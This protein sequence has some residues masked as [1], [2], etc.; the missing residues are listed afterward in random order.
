[1]KHKIVLVHGMGAHGKG[2][3]A[4]TQKKF[5]EQ[6]NKLKSAFAPNF[7]K[8]FDF[9]EVTYDHVFENQ[10]ARW[11]DQADK[12][13]ESLKIGGITSGAMEELVEATQSLGKDNFFTTHVLDVVLYKWFPLM[14]EEVRL[15]VANTFLETAKSSSQW[16]IIAHSLGTAVVHDTLE[17]MFTEN[18]DGKLL[19]RQYR[20]ANLWMVANVSR[21]V[22]QNDVYRS[23]VK[24]TLNSSHG[25]CN[26]Y[27]SV[28]HEFDPFPMVKPFQSN[29]PD[30]IRWR[31]EA[32]GLYLHV[33][34]AGKNTHDWNVHALSHYLEVPGCFFSIMQSFA[35]NLGINSEEME[36]FTKTYEEKTPDGMVRTI[37]EKFNQIN[38][39]DLSTIE[40]F[41]KTLRI[42]FEFLKSQGVSH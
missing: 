11:K 20:P 8:A 23:L 36:K 6:Y 13:Y 24:P 21:V 2:W 17:A 35:G 40:D 41:I 14:A 28:R 22:S 10:R 26:E 25:L 4:D 15:N 39:N 5:K 30:G 16:S 34:L 31:K 3:S 12:I 42:F 38:S 27:F 18:V 1:M 7:D 32:E 19:P 33:P 29:H 9:V 37:K